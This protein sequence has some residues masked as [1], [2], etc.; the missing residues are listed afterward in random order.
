M[1]GGGG[2]PF[3]RNVYDTLRHQNQD[4][5]VRH[6]VCMEEALRSDAEV[7]AVEDRHKGCGYSQFIHDNSP[8]V[9]VNSPCILICDTIIIHIERGKCK[10]DEGICHKSKQEDRYESTE[11]D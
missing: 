3:L 6:A 4:M 5:K 10:G 11:A 1:V 9:Y 7:A 2:R 8:Y